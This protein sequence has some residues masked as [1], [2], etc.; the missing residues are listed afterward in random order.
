MEPVEYIADYFAGC[1]LMP[2]RHLKA[3]FFSHTQS[4]ND[5]AVLFDVS[6]LAMTRR[7]AQLHLSDDRPPLQWD[8]P[9]A[10]RLLPPGPQDDRSDDPLT[11]PTSEVAA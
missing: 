11:T 6:E 1:V 2:K 4:V 10:S 8:S 9:P 3:A 7:L 5:L